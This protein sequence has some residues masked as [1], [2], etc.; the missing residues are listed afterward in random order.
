MRILLDTSYLFDFMDRPGMLPDSDRRVLAAG[1][2]NFYVSAVSVWEMR[3]K[4]HARHRSGERK[5]RFSPEEVVAALEEQDVTFLPMTMRHAASE[6][7][8][9][10]DHKD[11]FDELLLVQAQEEGLQ[12]LTVDRRLAGHPLAVTA[13]GLA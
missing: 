3:L 8:V 5:G 7:E 9:P 10:L 1:G 13:Q 4:Y 2:T 12:L 6:L 11:P